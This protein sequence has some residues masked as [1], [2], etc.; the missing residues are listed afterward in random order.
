MGMSG[1]KL[2]SLFLDP[3]FHRRGGGRRLVQHD[4]ALHDELTTDVNEQNP[5]ATCFY[6]ACGFV[7]ESRSEVDDM[8][9]PF[10]LLHLRWKKPIAN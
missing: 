3:E 10:P 6:E 4:Q 9:R 5:A 8:G 2:E 7:I 1:S